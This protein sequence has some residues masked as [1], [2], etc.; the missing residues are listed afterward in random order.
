MDLALVE[1]FLRVAEFGSINRAAED[2]EMTQP[3]L[4]RRLDSL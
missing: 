2:L 3:A 4:S 1:C